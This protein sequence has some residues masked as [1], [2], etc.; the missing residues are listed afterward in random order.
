MK[1]KKKMVN[2]VTVDLETIVTEVVGVIVVVISLC[3]L[4]VEKGFGYCK[5]VLNFIHMF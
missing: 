5:Q 1:T 3:L 2:V 4:M